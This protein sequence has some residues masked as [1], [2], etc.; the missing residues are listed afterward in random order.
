MQLLSCITKSKKESHNNNIT[1]LFH[2]Q[3]ACYL[4]PTQ[5]TIINQINQMGASEQQQEG[6]QF[7]KRGEK[8]T[9]HNLDYNCA[10]AAATADVN[11]D[12][13]ASDESFDF[14]NDK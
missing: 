13:N 12:S 7:I 5:R 10:A 3:D 9:I 11:N 6:I 2:F 14:D 4:C 1:P 8:V